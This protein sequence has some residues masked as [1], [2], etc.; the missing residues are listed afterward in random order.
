MKKRVNGVAAALVAVAVVVAGGVFLFRDHI[1]GQIVHNLLTKQAGV[2]LEQKA[3][4]QSIN[5][6]SSA[7]LLSIEQLVLSNF[8]DPQSQQN[9]AADRVDL[10]VVVAG[11]LSPEVLVRHARVYNAALTLEYI[12]PGVSNLQMIEESYRSYIQQRRAEGKKRRLQW[13]LERVE[14]YDLRFRL[15]DY[16]GKQLADVVIPRIALHSLGTG[17]TPADNVAAFLRQVQVSVIEET[18]K[19]RVTG[20]YD[21]RGLLKLAR[22]ELP[23]SR[24]MEN[25]PVDVLK[26]MGRSLLER[27]N[28]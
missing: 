22:T 9:F 19:G 16:E 15:I 28:Q 1:T 21:V 23:H 6:D 27:F 17:N 3:Q 2:A 26:G 8:D 25:G 10:D 7:G 24:F 12:A 20:D 14:L 18:I 5:L 11:V 4:F 13:D